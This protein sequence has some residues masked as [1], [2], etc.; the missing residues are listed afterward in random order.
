MK[1]NGVVV[2]N[3]LREAVKK[4][5]KIDPKDREKVEQVALW[6]RRRVRQLEQRPEAE[7][8][9]FKAKASGE[10]EKV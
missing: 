4:F 3:V 2:L 9:D 5:G 8:K 10:F 1:A 6:V 7:V